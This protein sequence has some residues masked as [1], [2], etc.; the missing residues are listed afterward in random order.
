VVL[1]GLDRASNM[2]QR[3]GK[4]SGGRALL[5]M[6]E[7]GH[8]LSSSSSEEELYS[9]DD[10]T[11][12]ESKEKLLPGGEG[13]EQQGAGQQEE[14]WWVMALQ[15]FFPFLVA[16]FGMVAAGLGTHHMAFASLF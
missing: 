8:T 9:A 16:G 3:M 6:E 13:A 14:R 4:S 10:E 15:V 7:L 11:E 2:G 1:G 5:G 12:D